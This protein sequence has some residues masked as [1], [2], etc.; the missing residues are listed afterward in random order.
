LL[1]G[2]LTLNRYRDGSERVLSALAVDRVSGGYMVRLLDHASRQQL[3]CY[4]TSWRAIPRVIEASLR[5]ANA[6][7]RP[8][9]SFLVKAPP[10]RKPAKES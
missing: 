10:A 4:A 7:W 3:S 9:N 6:V 2:L 5:S 1:W 8:Y